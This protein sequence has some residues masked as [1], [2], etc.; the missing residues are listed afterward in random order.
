MTDPNDDIRL[1]YESTWLS[2]PDLRGRDVTLT[3]ARVKGGEVIGEK[4]KKNKKA[5]VYWL[6]KARDGSEIKPMPLNKTNL[7]TVQSIYGTGF[8]IKALVGKRVT[9]YPTTTQ[10]G[11]QTVDCVRIRPVK[12]GDKKPNEAPPD[13]DGGNR[14]PGEEG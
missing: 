3:I 5:I 2:A 13:V 4:G 8:S 11:G 10:M 1:L 7:K 14:E 9:L 6:E 12:P